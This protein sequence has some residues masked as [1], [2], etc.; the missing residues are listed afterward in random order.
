MVVLLVAAGA[1]AP[2]FDPVVAA[3]GVGCTAEIVTVTDHALPGTLTASLVQ[4]LEAVVVLSGP[5]SEAGHRV[6][7][8]VRDVTSVPLC[9]VCASTREADEVLAFANGCDHVIH[10][11]CSPVLLRARLGSLVSRGRGHRDPV[12]TFGCLRVDPQLR[13]ATVREEPVDLT[14][15]EFEIV[16]TLVANQRR[17]VTRHELLEVAWGGCQSHEHVL[18]VH[19]S[20][21][22][23]KIL[24]AGGPRLGD[25]VPGVGYRVGH[26]TCPPTER[27]PYGA[28]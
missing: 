17:V 18:D 19:L 5:E 22:R 26:V 28:A 15:T 24:A 8:M 13:T 2:P 27:S 11:P 4:S 12:M 14:R 25:P 7:R 1:D 23:A 20:R 9:M 6:C 16:A 10:S 21:L 3:L